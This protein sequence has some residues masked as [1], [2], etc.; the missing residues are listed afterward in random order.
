MPEAQV[1]ERPSEGQGWWG[2]L[3]DTFYSAA[4]WTGDKL[5]IDSAVEAKQQNDVRMSDTPGTDLLKYMATQEGFKPGQAGNA[6]LTK[7]Q[8]DPQFVA[9]LNSALKSDTSIL[10]RMA[11]AGQNGRRDKQASENKRTTQHR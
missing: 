5:G 6:N 11:A 1:Q 4:L 2:S 7:V 9:A 8:N 10:T 3:K